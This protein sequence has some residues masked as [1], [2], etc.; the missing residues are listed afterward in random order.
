MSLPLCS[1]VA[2]LIKK[3]NKNA[4]LNTKYRAGTCKWP[5]PIQ[6]ATLLFII[7]P[8]ILALI[9]ELEGFEGTWR[10]MSTLAP[11]RLAALRKIA[12][13]ESIASSRI[14]GAKLSDRQ[15]EALAAFFSIAR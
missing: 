3:R 10:T 8:E 7:P 9:A 15:V 13:I 6:P 11:D 5:S 1:N 12:T 2:A 4:T 14:E